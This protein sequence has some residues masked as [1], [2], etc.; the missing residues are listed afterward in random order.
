M[1]NKT[2]IHSILFTALVAAAP[3]VFAQDTTSGAD[4]SAR[5][6]T[7]AA[8]QPDVRAEQLAAHYADVA[9]STEAAAAQVARLQSTSADAGAMAYGEVDTAMALSAAMVE[10]GAA[11]GFDTAVD[12]VA[13]LRA[14]GMGWGEI[15]QQFDVNLGAAVSS[16]HRADVASQVAGSAAAGTSVAGQARTGAN[17]AADAVVGTAGSLVDGVRAEVGRNAA[18]RA[19]V[20]AGVDVGADARG[21]AAGRPAGAEAGA[22]GSIGVDI[23]IGAGAP[24]RPSRPERPVLPEVPVLGGGLL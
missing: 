21:N 3:S 15:A 12:S 16:A 22:R 9:G 24:D 20:D 8:A 1:N 17:T 6:A 13:G 18:A 7:Q 10:S 11:T 2:L 4:A 19:R 5:A 14:E 23:G